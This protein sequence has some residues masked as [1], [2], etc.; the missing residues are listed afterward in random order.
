M[1]VFAVA[2][3]GMQAVAWRDLEVIQLGRQVHVLQLA[4]GS[5]GYV[6]WEP[7]GSPGVVEFLGQLVRERLDYASNVNCHV[8][9]VNAICWGCGVQPEVRTWP[10]DP[11]PTLPSRS[12]RSDSMWIK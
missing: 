8:T 6:G 3:E 12:L 10:F 2:P 9:H 4:R 1:L 11:H 7:F 5:T